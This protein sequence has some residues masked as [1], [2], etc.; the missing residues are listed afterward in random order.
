MGTKIRK[1]FLFAFIIYCILDNSDNYLQALDRCKEQEQLI[2]ELQG[3][4]E[5][6]RKDAQ[7]EIDKV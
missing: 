5:T 2:E 4:L 7:S 3:P 1:T 6:L